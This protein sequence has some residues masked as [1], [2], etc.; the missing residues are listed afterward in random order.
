MG[1]SDL[2]GVFWRKYRKCRFIAGN[3][4]T[5][6]QIDVYYEN[7]SYL[8]EWKSHVVLFGRVNSRSK[9]E[10]STSSSVSDECRLKATAMVRV[11]VVE[12]SVAVEMESQT[13]ARIH[14]APGEQNYLEE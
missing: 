2:D 8:G 9:N 13:I 7:T 5:A 14:S 11:V 6:G 3:Q 1:L 4:H 12:E 10:T